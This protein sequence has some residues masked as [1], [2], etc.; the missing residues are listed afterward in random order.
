M[1]PSGVVPG[2]DGK[3]MFSFGFCWFWFGFGWKTHVF[4]WFLLG[5]AGIYVFLLFS[6]VLGGK[7][8]F[9]FVFNGFG[10]KTY[11]FL[12]FLLVFGRTTNVFLWFLMISGGKQCF[13]WFLMVLVGKP[14]FWFLIKK[15]NVLWDKIRLKRYPKFHILAPAQLAAGGC[16]PLKATPGRGPAARR[17]FFGILVIPI[18]KLMI[19]I[20]I[21][22]LFQSDSTLFLLNIIKITK[23]WNCP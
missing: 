22:M 3:P 16:S 5:L 15:C 21:L 8:M 1:R 17:N 7:P 23:E 4:L 11:V 10:W 2:F 6:L 18:E 19:F 9:S 20:N 13:L 12:W 14:M